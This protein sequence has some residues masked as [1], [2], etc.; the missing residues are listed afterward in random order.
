[1][2]LKTEKKQTDC[3]FINAKYCEFASQPLD[4]PVVAIKRRMVSL[5]HSVV[6]LCNAS[7]G[8]LT[9]RLQ[10]QIIPI[11]VP[12]SF[13]IVHTVAGLTLSSCPMHLEKQPLHR[14]FSTLSLG[15]A[16]TS[17]KRLGARLQSELISGR[18]PA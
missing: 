13:S 16:Y 3:V 6:V 18:C 12:D 7:Y 9:R 2:R 5:P 1:L 14:S 17:Q 15:P 8:G 10:H 11:D 4:A